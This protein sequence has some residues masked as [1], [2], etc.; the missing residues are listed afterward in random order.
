MWS[1]QLSSLEKVPLEGKD[2]YE[3]L[4]LWYVVHWLIFVQ[5]GQ[6]ETQRSIFNREKEE[7]KGDRLKNG[8]GIN[9]YIT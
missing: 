6:P 8:R 3:N 1:P 2:K 5:K 9:R 7:E 4:E